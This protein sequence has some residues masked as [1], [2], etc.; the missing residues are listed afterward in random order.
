MK[1]VFVC[2]CMESS[3]CS[4]LPPSKLL[5]CSNHVHWE[6]GIVVWL[7][8]RFAMLFNV[9]ISSV[10]FDSF[11]RERWQNCIAHIQPLILT[12]L[13]IS[14]R[15]HLVSLCQATARAAV[16]QVTAVAQLPFLLPLSMAH[17]TSMVI[18]AR[19][20]SVLEHCSF[21]FFLLKSAG[22]IFCFQ[23]IL[24]SHSSFSF[25]FSFSF[26]SLI[27]LGFGVFVRGEDAHH[28]VYIYSP[29]PNSRL[30]FIGSASK[31]FLHL[32]ISTLKTTATSRK[33]QKQCV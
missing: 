33:R 13:A 16:T 10:R 30:S 3:Y 5:I 8:E 4:F 6:K 11:W 7:T 12:F 32:T 24:H 27:S 18:N 29:R 22:F 15:S 1:C 19:H 14:G 31:C 17:R 20:R 26:F 25:S 23:Y 21:Y 28:G 2:M 9:K